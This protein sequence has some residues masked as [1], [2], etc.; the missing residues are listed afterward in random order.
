MQQK[1]ATQE[2]LNGY[3]FARLTKAKQIIGVFNLTKLK[4]EVLILAG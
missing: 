3:S 4:R 2:K 1:S